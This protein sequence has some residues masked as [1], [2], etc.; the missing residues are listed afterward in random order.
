[1]EEED[2]KT[3]KLKL[4]TVLWMAGA[5]LVALTYLLLHT[6]LIFFTSI[7]WTGILLSGIATYIVISGDNKTHTKLCFL[8]LFGL[9]LYLPHVL[10]SPNYYHL[11]DEMNHYQSSTLVY[12]NGSLNI[13]SSFVISKYYPTLEILTVFFKNIDGDTIFNSGLIIVGIIHSLTIVFLYLFFR[14][15]CSAKIASIGAFAYFFNN[16]YTYTDSWVSYESIGFPLLVICLFAVS[17]NY[18]KIRMVPVQF[19]LILGLV[20]THH[21]S[22]YIFLL[23]LLILLFVKRNEHGEV[24]V[25]IRMLTILTATLIFTWLTFVVPKTLVYYFN[26]LGPSL[27]GVAGRLLFAQRV[28][29]IL[30]NSFL[31]IPYYELFIRRYLY[32]PLIL[33]FMLIGLYYLN[34]K[35]R[36]D[37]YAV[38]MVIFSA[39]FF[40][41]L[42]G[43][44]TSS[45][46]ISRFSTF[47]FTGIA[48]FIGISINEF[49]KHKILKFL[50][51]IFIVIILIGGISLGTASPYRGSYSGNVAFGQQTITIDSI[52]SAE[53]SEKYMG[54]YNTIASDH[55]TG[56]VL[57]YYGM[58]RSITNWEIFYP[59]K[60]DGNVTYDLRYNNASYVA[61][62][63]RITKYTSELHYYF[64][65]DELYMNNSYGN[66]KPFP[67]DLIKKFDNSEFFAKI[68]DNGDI[69]IYKLLL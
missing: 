19:I 67:I 55:T 48:F 25:R 14:N 69:N 26:I 57:E 65:R 41:S 66:T 45:F 34:N 68:Y 15:I 39:M 49:N 44:V 23:F 6:K 13:N 21:F 8:F 47:G 63:E 32:I 53:W 11:Y 58:Q 46:E 9:I 33:I 29:E 64:S 62:D 40:M 37:A 5:F 59:T 22:S 3:L 28:S 56:A 31:D 60:V 35:K 2:K 18:N 12:E 42:I 51:V 43:M 30:S 16:S 24:F 61:T 17:Y 50:I 7:F 10:S 1:M 4:I 20:A 38:A 27:E 36:L 52:S 54:K